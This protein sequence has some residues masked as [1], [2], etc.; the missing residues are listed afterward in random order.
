MFAT[1]R[2]LRLL[3][4]AGIWYMD[5]TFKSSPLLFYHIYIIR[6]S[7][8]DTAVSCVYVFLT[9][10]DQDTY[11]EML[12]ELVSRALQKGFYLDPEVVVTDFELAVTSALKV[13]IGPQVDNK[14]CFFHLTKNTWK[15]FKKL[16]LRCCIA[17]MKMCV[18]SSGC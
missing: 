6:A 1:D 11:E 16:E 9:R 13:I 14:Y 2:C 10:N 17:P 5:G 18:T 7:L 8:A 12:Q 15:K 4:R 3:S